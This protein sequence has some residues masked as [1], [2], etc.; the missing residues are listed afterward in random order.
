MTNAIN[1]TT[2]R[3]WG[4][5]TNMNGYTQSAPQGHYQSSGHFLP[6]TFAD[7]F[8]DSFDPSL[9]NLSHSMTNMMLQGI[10]YTG[11][12]KQNHPNAAA[13][14]MAGMN[15]SPG[16]F[17]S[18]PNGGLVYTD[19]HGVHQSAYSP[20]V[21]TYGLNAP[22]PGQFHQA[23][24]HGVFP[25]TPI[26]PR[27]NGWAL[28]QQLPQEVPELAAPRR[29]SLSS[30]EADS[31][32]TPLFTSYLGGHQ[33]HVVGTN[34]QW[35]AMGDY[36]SPHPDSPMQIA[37]DPRG[38]PVLIN[39]EMWTT[40]PPAIPPAIPAIDSPG[41]GRGS[42]DQIMH[43]PQGTL[44]VYV[45]GLHPNTTDEMLLAYGQKFGEVESAKSIV[46]TTGRCKGF[47]F[48][49]Y[50]NF[51]DAENCIRGFY[52]RKYEA[53]FARVGHN[54]R[55][56]TLANP[57]NT[58]LYLSNLPKN[59]NEADLQAIFKAKYPEFSIVNHKVLK[60]ENGLSRGVGFARFETHEICDQIIA[61]FS[62]LLLDEETDSHLQI[63][64]ADT[65][66]QKEFKA[67]TAKSREFK[68]TEYDRSLKYCQ[69]YP[70]QGRYVQ[71]PS[72]LGGP[73]TLINPVPPQ[74]RASAR[75][76]IESPSEVATTKQSSTT[77]VNS[78]TTSE[79]D[80][81]PVSKLDFAALS[82]GEVQASPTKSKL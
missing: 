27:G 50:K 12:T 64:Y 29:T 35:N 53:K 56:K 13:H 28:P 49:K 41:G 74:A 18:L 47:G 72:G 46:D 37:K 23:S 59:M 73:N 68:T 25:H 24:I 33:P 10:D 1:N 66:E 38:Q 3:G 6:N 19:P 44:N 62:G 4:R 55:L 22:N 71:S 8:N 52:Y 40:K 69:L 5:S 43:N 57:N 78:P 17:Y 70:W 11:T 42:L 79:E 51:N 14:G 48:I 31:P 26:T 32:Q 20:Y 67:K 54:A 60:D 9:N 61:E 7:G 16:L 81:Q 77:L 75:V 63:R 45:R 34:Q 82:K 15:G 65:D 2:S 80:A 58:N 30:N 76:K 21:G 36:P 39:F